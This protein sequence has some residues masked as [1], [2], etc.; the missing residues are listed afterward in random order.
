MQPIRRTTR[1]AALALTAAGTLALTAGAATASADNVVTY[2]GDEVNGSPRHVISYE[3]PGFVSNNLVIRESGNEFTLD[4]VVPITVEGTAT[5]DCHHD[6]PADKTIVRCEPD[7]LVGNR[8]HRIEVSLFNGDNKLVHL[9]S[10]PLT[11]TGIGAVANHFRGG[12]GP[13]NLFGGDGRDVLLGGNG[14]DTLTGLGGDDGLS[15]GPGGDTLRGAGGR[16]ELIPNGGFDLLE[17][18]EGRDVA[19]YNERT[20]PVTVT[21]DGLANDG[22][23]G[24]LDNVKSDVE[25]VTGGNG[26]DV[27]LDSVGAANTLTG[28]NGNDVIQGGA[29]ADTVSGGNGFDALDGGADA[30]ALSGDA[31]GDSLVGGTGADVMS[32]GTG[33]DMVSYRLATQ[34]V[35]VDLDGISDDGVAGEGD[36]VKPDIEDIKGGAASDVLTGDADA[37][38]IS[39]RDGNDVIEGG[40][41]ADVLVGDNDNDT[42]RSKD[43]IADT[44]DCGADPDQ[45]E[46]DAVDSQSGCESAAG[47]AVG[48]GPRRTHV[49]RR[50]RAELSL[51]CWASSVAHCKGTIRLKGRGGELLGRRAFRVRS[52]HTSAVRVPLDRAARRAVARRPRKARAVTWATDAGAHRWRSQ[53]RLT[54]VA[55]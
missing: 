55:R 50:G 14:N 40:L 20:Q 53:R 4:D 35:T 15:G 9:G 36:N 52:G 3:S 25:D 13:D 54:L 34:R 45:I 10:L 19:K 2:F 18:G 33:T 41:G 26:G 28:G 47:P 17:G 1:R 38:V 27:I 37:N 11:A 46:A 5:H 51:H 31:D 23:L 39:G 24:E 21:L 43:G 29:G 16:D 22:E 49:D 12:D 44:V 30:D 6:N 7:N 32:G 42:L 8:F 48:I